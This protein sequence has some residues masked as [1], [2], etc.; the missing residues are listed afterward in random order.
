MPTLEALYGFWEAN[1][2]SLSLLRAQETT[3]DRDPLHAIIEALKGR[4]RVLG[5]TETEAEGEANGSTQPHPSALA[6]PKDRRLRSKEHLAFVGKQPC[7]VCGRRPAHAHHIRF[8]QSRAMSLKVS[9]E[10]TVPLCAGHHD[11]LHKT[12]DE[13]AWWARHGVIEPLKFA[14]RLW[15]ASRLGTGDGDVNGVQE[16]IAIAPAQDASS[17]SDPGHNGRPPQTA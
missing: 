11:D 16:E 7:L 12:G 6:A 9:G 2:D 14:E 13:R 10:F 5:R 1:L 17:S 4:A 8:A 3:G 15:A